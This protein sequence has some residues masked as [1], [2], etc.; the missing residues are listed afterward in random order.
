MGGFCNGSPYP[1][2]WLLLLLLLFVPPEKE[3]PAGVIQKL[4]SDWPLSSGCYRI[5]S[6]VI[7]SRLRPKGTQKKRKKG[8]RAGPMN[9][10][11]EKKKL[12]KR[13]KNCLQKAKKGPAIVA[14]QVRKR[15]AF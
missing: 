9:G 8:E 12:R 4:A 14:T 7:K 10:E 5:K 2:W 15:L 3:L 11:R 6:D 1:F 13:K